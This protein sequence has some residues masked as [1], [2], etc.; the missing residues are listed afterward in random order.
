MKK[1]LL[2]FIVSMCS[3]VS[4][5]Q[6]G[7]EGESAR[8]EVVKFPKYV[9]TD[10]NSRTFS[11]DVKF[12]KKV[13]ETMDPN[14]VADQIKLYAWSRLQ[15]DAAYMK[16]EV[17]VGSFITEGTD[18]EN[19]ST[20]EKGVEK[21]DYRGVLDYSLP[22]SVV[23]TD[24]D[25]HS[26]TKDLCTGVKRY[27]PGKSS[28]NHRDALAYIKDNKDVLVEKIIL[29]ELKSAV[30]GV[31]DYMLALYSWDKELM[32][33]E[34]YHLDQKKSKYY[35]EQNADNERLK[36]LYKNMKSTQPVDVEEFNSI[37]ERYK[38]IINDLNDGDKKQKKAKI[39]LMLS[40]SE[41][42]LSMDKFD[43][44]RE[45]AEK[46]ISEYGESDGED[47]IKKINKAEAKIKDGKA[48][49]RHFRMSAPQIEEAE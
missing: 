34:Y 32:K 31:K 10:V 39:K 12:T 43:E 38:E 5:A 15:S 48:T 23:I 42:L 27:K 3:V 26:N 44:S 36:I 6:Y 21:P 46:V 18:V 20:V 24:R 13:A 19:H 9:I 4:F 8:Y 16:V 7:T 33:V 35:E 22:I 17:E 49:C 45:W 37:L 1:Y 40:V 14:D 47:I 11:V 29:D 2:T 25:G 28:K 30:G 41:I